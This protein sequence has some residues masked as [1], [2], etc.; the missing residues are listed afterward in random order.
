MKKAYLFL[1]SM[2][3]GMILLVLVML[4]SLAG[5]LV[6]QQEQAMTYVHAYGSTV[7]KAVLFIGLNDIFHTWYFY[8]L[9]LLLCFNLI[10]CSL[11]RFPRTL[12]SFDEM[13]KRTA[14]AAP[15]RKLV[16]GGAEKLR[17][18]LT[19]QRFRSETAG[20]GTWYDRNRVG[21]FGSFSRTWPSCSC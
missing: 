6:P 5:S 8:L 13:K 3:F 16:P 14:D 19:R 10:L 12:R 1:R 20:D 18:W 7:A 9:T 17:A 11:L 2:K 15:E 4:C 21:V